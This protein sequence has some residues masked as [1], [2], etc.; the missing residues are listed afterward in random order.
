M[1]NLNVKKQI[2]QVIGLPRFNV[3]RQI[4]LHYTCSFDLQHDNVVPVSRVQ[5]HFD[6][7]NDLLSISYK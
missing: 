5:Q 3:F 7:K 2:P 1:I 4:K 6:F